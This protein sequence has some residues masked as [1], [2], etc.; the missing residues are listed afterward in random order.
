M[1]IKIDRVKLFSIFEYFILSLIIILSFF[2]RLYKINSPIA[3]WHSWRQADTA[4]VSRRYLNEGIDLLRP[5]YYDISSIQTGKFNPDGLRF[6][7]FPVFNVIHLFFYS[8]FEP[9]LSFD[10]SGRMVSVVSSI[11]SLVLIYFI[12]KRLS[13]RW[14]GLL[15][16]F[17]YGSMPFNIYFNRTVLPEPLAVCFS[18]LG[19]YLF[20]EYI[21]RDK[22]IFVLLSGISFSLAILTKPY[23]VFYG[24]PVIY[25]AYKKF[26]F[27]GLFR[28]KALLISLDIVLI[29]F[30]LWRGW[31]SKDQFFIGIPHAEWVFNGDGIRFKPSF[32][33][34]IFGE[35]VGTMILGVWGVVPFVYGVS[36]S[37][38]YVK[39]Y[40]MFFLYLIAGTAVYL[41][42]V[43][44]ANVKHD[45]YQILIVP[46]ICM[47][48]SYGAYY[49]VKETKFVV[50]K[51]LLI[52]CI[53]MMVGVG[54][55]EVRGFYSINH[56]EIIEAGSALEKVADEDA[57][58]VAPYNGDTTFLYYT[59][60]AGWP[61]VDTS[62]EKLIERG[63][64]YYVSVSKGDS[65]TVTLKSRYEILLEEEN[66]IIIDLRKPL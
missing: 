41:S 8:N 60:R 31:M 7:E 22:T 44:T 11:F 62:F 39:R 4:S 46:P 33:R 37:I 14:V 25:L 5:R 66:Y 36:A 59:K 17:F 21:L 19:L 38:R 20:V 63:A 61:V 64:S 16:A 6:V 49:L 24:L 1:N 55:Y 52:F 40:S 12:L 32:W 51:I 65:D 29:P 45:Y 54:F 47:A 34:W 9:I 3:D 35:R 42:V 27:I 26:G 43:A 53:F 18:L 23:T 50:D 30:F 10:A 56:P 48:L 28:N 58:V 15:G 57:L 2:V 13:N